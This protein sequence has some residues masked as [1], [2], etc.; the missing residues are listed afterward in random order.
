MGAESKKSL[1]NTD[2]V[3]CF[4]NY[5]KPRGIKEL[6]WTCTKKKFLIKFT[7]KTNIV[8]CHVKSCIP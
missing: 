7:K 4:L 5:L 2:L 1:R 6:C 8:P 3:T